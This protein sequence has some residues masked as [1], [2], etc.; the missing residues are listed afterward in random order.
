VITP[1]FRSSALPLL[2]KSDLP[3][4]KPPKSPSTFSKASWATLPTVHLPVETL[5]CIGFILLLSG[6]ASCILCFYILTLTGRKYFLDFGAISG[7]TSFILGLLS[8]RTNKWKWLPHRNYLTG[9][10]MLA[11]FSMVSCG[12]LAGILYAVLTKNSSIM[13]TLGGVVCGMCAVV[14]TGSLL[15]LVTSGCCHR[16]PPD[17]RVAHRVIGF[18]V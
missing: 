7:F 4:P 8:F 2:D 12:C 6:A 5:C 1:N 15:G 10:L 18:T 9:F 3:Q 16:P 17:N 13:D 11:L 14:T